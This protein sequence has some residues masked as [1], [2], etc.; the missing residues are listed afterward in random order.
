MRRGPR[1][2]VLHPE[3]RAAIDRAARLLGDLGHRVEE[4]HPDALDDPAGVMHFAAI[5]AANVARTL[6]VWAERVGRR[7]GPEDVEPHVWAFA[8]RGRG[9]SS[10]DFLASLDAVHAH[11]R[12]LAAWWHDG[13]DLLLT[14][15]CAEPPPPL[16]HMTSTAEEPYR[17]LLR[18]MPYSAFTS[19]FNLSGQPAISLPLHWTADDL[20]VGVQLVAAF[21]REDLL[22]QVAAQLEQAAPWKDRQPQALA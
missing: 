10:A 8:E 5:V 11:S 4:S 13:F 9:L 22:L 12:R 19:A 15:T 21:G 3:C 1:D 17:G 14:P 7:V 20:P 16:G 6:D 18:A 2:V